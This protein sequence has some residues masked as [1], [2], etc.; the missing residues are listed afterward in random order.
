M[1]FFA[2]RLCKGVLIGQNGVLTGQNGADA[3]TKIKN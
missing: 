2:D 3:T 1:L